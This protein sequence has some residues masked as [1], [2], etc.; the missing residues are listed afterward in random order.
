[1]MD[2]KKRDTDLAQAGE[3]L[4]RAGQR[5]RETA[6]R[7]HTPL[8]TYKDGHVRKRMVVRETRTKDE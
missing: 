1:M 6:E 8:V 7:T 3:A 5:A 4:K 2:K